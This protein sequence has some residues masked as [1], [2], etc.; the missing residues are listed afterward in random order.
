MRKEYRDFKVRQI[1]DQ[2]CTELPFSKKNHLT[3]EDYTK[4]F[5]KFSEALP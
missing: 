4:M 2:R 5:K 3:I 1:A